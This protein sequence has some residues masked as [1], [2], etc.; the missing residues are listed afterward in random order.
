MESISFK[1][2]LENRV[3]DIFDEDCLEALNLGSRGAAT[4]LY[5]EEYIGPVVTEYLAWLIVYSEDNRERFETFM[6]LV[7]E[8]KSA[9]EQSKIE[10]E[11]A[12]ARSNIE[13]NI[14][15]IK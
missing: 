7:K 3:I 11:V 14:K 12:V 13:R 5:V 6:K 9:Y 1:E 2:A 15:R 8:I 10:T 4:D